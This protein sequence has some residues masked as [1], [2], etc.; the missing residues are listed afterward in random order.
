MEKPKIKVD[1]D[2]W[3]PNSY[4]GRSK[5]QVESTLESM[6][7]LGRILPWVIVALGVCAFIKA[8]F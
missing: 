1:P 3:D 4:Q 8:V 5:K 2:V 7:L 6:S